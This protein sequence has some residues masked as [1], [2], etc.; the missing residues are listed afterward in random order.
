M[1]KI[2]VSTSFEIEGVKYLSR[3]DLVRKLG[4][5]SA[6]FKREK[7]IL[8]DYC[9]ELR[10]PQRATVYSARQVKAF[11]RLRELK[12]MFCG[13]QLIDYLSENGINV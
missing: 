7:A 8:V 2:A 9:P 13:Q 12:K 4:L 10:I 3:A 5:S 11:V 1:R 6:Q